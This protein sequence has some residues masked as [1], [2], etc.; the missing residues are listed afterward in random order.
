VSKTKTLLEASI[1]RRMVSDVPVAA[2]LSGGIDSSAIVSMMAK[3]NSQPVK[4][5]S[6]AF[7]DKNL[8]E[9]QYAKLIAKRFNT[10]HLETRMDAIEVLDDLPNYF[11]MLDSPT[12]DGINVYAVSRLVAKNGLKVALSGVGGD[13]LFGGY[14]GFTRYIN[15][16]NHLKLLSNPAT[17][18]II[19]NLTPLFKNR[20]LLKLDDLVTNSGKMGLQSFYKSNRSIYLKKQIS[21]LVN[22]KYAPRKEDGSFGSNDQEVSSFPYYSQYS[23][24]E[25]SN[26]TLDVL[27]KDM[28]QL[29]MAWGLEV[30]EPFFDVPLIEFLL[31][32]PD[33]F[34]Y[35]ADVPKKL[36]VDAMSGELPKEITHRKKKGFVFP[37]ENWF[38]NEW[39]DYCDSSINLLAK[40]GLF[41]YS[42]LKNLW[43]SFLKYEKG[44]T[45]MHVWSLV[46][47][48]NW[49][50]ENGIEN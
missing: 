18:F 8:D 42:Q 35:S 12:V 24:S 17:K 1:K 25:L 22:E 33:K 46:V 23:I 38:R 31:T 37:L 20:S 7:S 3:E 47:L 16:T 2:F 34:K 40:R 21:K 26:Y 11:R 48:E 5:F 27:L 41:E 36:L 28:D 44:V 50:A 30:R 15:F 14:V 10:D 4:T 9:S 13:E 32:V 6:L 29:S 45:W 19:T 49:L 43:A 39:K